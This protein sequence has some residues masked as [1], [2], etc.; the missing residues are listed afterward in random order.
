MDIYRE[1][2]LRCTSYGLM[3]TRSYGESYGDTWSLT[4]TRAIA[5]LLFHKRQYIDFF[6]ALEGCRE[7]RGYCT[8]HRNSLMTRLDMRT[9]SPAHRA[10]AWT[11]WYEIPVLPH[12]CEL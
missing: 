10:A 1:A 7:F 11:S 2:V 5:P 6:T 9:L 8:C 12:I 4:V 3:V